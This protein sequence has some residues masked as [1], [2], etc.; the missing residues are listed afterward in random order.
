MIIWYDHVPE[1]V[2]ENGNNK[3]MWDSILR[4][5]QETEARRPDLVVINKRDEQL[6]YR[7]CGSR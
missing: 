7:R 2:S 3:L 5:D 6:P 1:S 4:T